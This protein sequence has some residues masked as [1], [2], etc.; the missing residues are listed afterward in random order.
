MEESTSVSTQFDGNLLTID[1][2]IAEN[3]RLRPE[4]VPTLRQNGRR[5]RWNHSESFDRR[6]RLD[7]LG[8]GQRFRSLR[9]PSGNYR[10]TTDFNG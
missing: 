2:I 7:P 1:L 3:D 5:L 9:Q 6:R 4:L 10:S 8:D